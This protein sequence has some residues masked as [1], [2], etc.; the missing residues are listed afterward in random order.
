MKRN[1]YD[2]AARAASISSDSRSHKH[3]LLSGD[4]EIL[5][6]RISRFPDFYTS[7][8]VDF[9][10]S[11]NLENWKSGNLK[12]LQAFVVTAGATSISCY[13]KIQKS[14]IAGWSGN[15]DG[16][17]NIDCNKRTETETTR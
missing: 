14:Y 7:R 8:F 13:R 1:I 2:H 4:P 10:I 12:I 11:G 3:T 15:A 16:G 9:H 5:Q 17:G 6:R